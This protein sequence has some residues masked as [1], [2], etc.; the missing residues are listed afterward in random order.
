F[1]FQAEDGIRYRTVTGVQT[2]ALP[3]LFV[4]L[5]RQMSWVWIIAIIAALVVVV[6]V[7]PILWRMILATW[8]ALIATH[9][10]KEGERLSNEMDRLRAQGFTGNELIA[11]VQKKFPLTRRR[12]WY[13]ELYALLIGR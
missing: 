6:L 5:I 13:V 4:G 2:C 1:F 9:A 8:V 12:P 11:E 10:Q 3:I 7:S